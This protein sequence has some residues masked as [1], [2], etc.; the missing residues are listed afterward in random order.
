MFK[1]VEAWIFAL[2]WFLNLY[3]ILFYLFVFASSL[4][5][6]YTSS[7]LQYI[8]SIFKLVQEPR[9]TR[10]HLALFCKSFVP[11]IIFSSQ[12]IVNIHHLTSTHFARLRQLD[13]KVNLTYISCVYFCQLSFIF[14]RFKVIPCLMLAIHKLLL[15]TKKVKKNKTKKCC[16]KKM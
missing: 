15:C 4:Q 16:F 10:K 7:R 13:I 8:S 1:I 2:K 11:H 3:F 9:K 5:V 14:L 12:L 6:K